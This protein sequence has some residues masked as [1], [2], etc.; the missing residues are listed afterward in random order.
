MLS[1]FSSKVAFNLSSVN[2]KLY[3]C[4]PSFYFLLIFSNSMFQ[5]FADPSIEPDSKN[6]PFGEKSQK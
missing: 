4:P 2:Y 6:L 3:L 1:L 5:T